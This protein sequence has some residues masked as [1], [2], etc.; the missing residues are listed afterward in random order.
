MKRKSIAA[1]IAFISMSFVTAC[2]Q[3]GDSTPAIEQS[4][5]EMEVSQV[6]E[7]ASSEA[8]AMEEP[9]EER[10]AT[11]A[12]SDEGASEAEEATEET[13]NDEA[14]WTGELTEEYALAKLQKVSNAYGELEKNFNKETEAHAQLALATA[15]EDVVPVDGL[16]TADGF[17]SDQMAEGGLQGQQTLVAV[18]LQ[19]ICKYY[20]D[21]INDDG[22]YFDFTDYIS[23]HELDKDLVIL[24]NAIHKDS[25]ERG[26][27]GEIDTNLGTMYNMAWIPALCE[28]Q[29]SIENVTNEPKVEKNY[30]FLLDGSRVDV[31]SQCDIYLDGKDTGIKAVFDKD[32]NFLNFNDENATI[33]LVIPFK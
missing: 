4:N 11:V 2:G 17:T 20:Y 24:F 8:V 6:S 3:S 12:S 1:I 7:E 13:A 23:T 16:A 28:G 9:T 33:D 32:G 25:V 29:M 14:A 22:D 18:Y 27:A 19:T 31:A 10:E 5:A 15:F 26:V 21:Y 30:V